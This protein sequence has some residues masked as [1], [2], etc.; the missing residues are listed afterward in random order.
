MISFYK[1]SKYRNPIVMKI[2]LKYKFPVKYEKY[3]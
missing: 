1:F 2:P 3:K